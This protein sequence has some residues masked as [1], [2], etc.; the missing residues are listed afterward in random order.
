MR[1]LANGKEKGMILGG[2]AR[3]P[4]DVQALHEFGLQFAEI[5]ILDL[6]I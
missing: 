3:S 2:T 5:P 6:W 4:Q 1:G